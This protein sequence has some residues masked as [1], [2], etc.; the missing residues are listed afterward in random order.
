ME[1]RVLHRN[2]CS[3]DP[4]PVPIKYRMSMVQSNSIIRKSCTQGCVCISWL[5]PSCLTDVAY[6]SASNN[7]ELFSQIGIQYKKL[8]WLENILSNQNYWSITLTSIIGKILESIVRDT[9]F[10][11]FNNNL[12]CS[13]QHGFVPRRSCTSQLL[14]AMEECIKAIQDNKYLRRCGLFGLY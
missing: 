5:I 1:W 9:Q 10:A 13:N 2:V 3:R 14:T 4:F 6:H 8:S 7:N 11:H 12:L